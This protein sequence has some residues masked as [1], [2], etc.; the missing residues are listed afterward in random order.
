[1]VRYNGLSLIAMPSLDIVVTF[2]HIIIKV[3]S[4][5]NKLNRFVSVFTQ[6][7]HA[8]VDAREK[9]LISVR[10]SVELKHYEETT[11]CNFLTRKYW[12][13]LSENWFV[14]CLNTCLDTY[15][16]SKDLDY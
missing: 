4:D 5:L 16:I 15:E 8:L 10:A 3:Q 7:V 9:R 11:L 2:F 13:N 12:I 1:M 6:C 14:S